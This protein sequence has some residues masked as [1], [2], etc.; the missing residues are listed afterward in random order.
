MSLEQVFVLRFQSVSCCSNCCLQLGALSQ[1]EN[2]TLSLIDSAS[3]VI[4]EV[5]RCSAGIHPLQKLGFR[6]S[7]PHP[8]A[9]HCRQGFVHN[10]E[11]GER[12]P[13]FFFF[14]FPNLF[15]LLLWEEASEGPGQIRIKML[16]KLMYKTTVLAISLPAMM[17]TGTCQGVCR[18]P[19]QRSLCR[20]HQLQH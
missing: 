10:F 5:S 13:F 17:T 16:I 7:V 1:S 15:L 8:M 6:E 18:I 11:V 2:E 4:Q 3:F 20:R 12:I 14:S 9:W 19:R